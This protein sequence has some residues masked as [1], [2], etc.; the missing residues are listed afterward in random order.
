[1][2]AVAASWQ[3]NSIASCIRVKPNGRVDVKASSGAHI[4]LLQ[5]AIDQLSAIHDAIPDV[6]DF[7]LDGDTHH[8]G[9]S[10]SAAIL[11]QLHADGLVHLNEFS[12]RMTTPK[13][14]AWKKMN[15]LALQMPT[16]RKALQARETRMPA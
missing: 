5:S 3:K 8:I 15:R 9:I 7:D 10:G 6:N 1:M 12:S 4:K 16:A 13:H 2:I 14:K 11:E